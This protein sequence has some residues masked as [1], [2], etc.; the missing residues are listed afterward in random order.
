ML[1][2]NHINMQLQINEFK[3]QKIS[4]NLILINLLMP[5][6]LNSI[7]IATGPG[8]GA[9]GGNI[10]RCKKDGQSL[11]QW[12]LLD[13]LSLQ[14]N[15]SLSTAQDKNLISYEENNTES[16]N[17]TSNTFQFIYSAYDLKLQS[18][19]ENNLEK[20]KYLKV[21]NSSRQILNDWEVEL[22]KNPDYENIFL[23]KWIRNRL[24]NLNVFWSPF[25]FVLQDKFELPS[26]VESNCSNGLEIKTAL[27]YDPLFGVFI[28]GPLWN[29]L[30]DQL[31]SFLLIKESIRQLQ[32]G[33]L[34]NETN[35]NVQ[36]TTAHL[37]LGPNTDLGI[38]FSQY[39]NERIQ[40]HI[41]GLAPLIAMQNITLNQINYNLLMNMLLNDPIREILTR[42]MTKKI[43]SISSQEIET[44]L[45]ERNLIQEKNIEPDSK[46]W[47]S[48]FD[49][50]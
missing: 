23:L 16:T 11:N 42:K 35:L 3:I 48:I 25:E 4:L 45:R 41:K 49:F 43:Q 10:V 34:L 46:S 18:L 36:K 38:H 37:V 1:L 2:A 31:K 40:P 28:S 9:G 17:K 14:P 8:D 21:L 26:D 6:L 15:L 27:L 22:N 44:S 24:D 39:F 50:N 33:E 12:V 19:K 7:G 5:F 30:S 13:L 29:Q 20:A 32:L 47:F